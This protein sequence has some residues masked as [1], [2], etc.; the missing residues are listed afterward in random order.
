MDRAALIVRREPAVDLMRVLGEVTVRAG[1]CARDRRRAKAPPAGG[2]ACA[3]PPRI[4]PWAATN[5]ASHAWNAVALPASSTCNI[6]S[7]VARAS[8]KLGQGP[9]GCVQCRRSASIFD[10]GS[11]EG[12]LSSIA[13]EPRLSASASS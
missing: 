9:A 13:S 12:S 4:A 7:T 1:G 10:S 5:Q 11:A 8:G 6:R 2:R 3:G